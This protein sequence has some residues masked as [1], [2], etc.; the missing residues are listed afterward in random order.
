MCSRHLLS[1]IRVC[2][3]TYSEDT[4]TLTCECLTSHPP[5]DHFYRGRDGERACQSARSLY[6]SQRRREGQKERAALISHGSPGWLCVIKM[7]GPP[8]ANTHRH[9]HTH[10]D[11]STHILLH[12]LYRTFSHTHTHCAKKHLLL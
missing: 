8:V 12:T 10:P 6:F 3:Y 5:P 2:L 4:L 7:D 11:Y 1:T 9:T